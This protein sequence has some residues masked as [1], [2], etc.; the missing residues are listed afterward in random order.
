MSTETK[1]A[2]KQISPTDKKLLRKMFLRSLTIGAPLQYA[3][4]YGS[5]FEY[6]ILPF[7]DHYYEP[8]SEKKRQAIKRHMV[9]YNITQYVG[10]FCQGLVASMEKQAAEHDDYDVNS[11]NAVKASLMGPMSGIGDTLFWGIL[12]VIAAGVAMSF[13]MQGNFL[14]P[15][16]F[17][18]IYNIPAQWCRWEMTKLGFTVGSEY[19]T[20]M[21][22]SGLLNIFTKAAKTLG[23]IMLGGMTSS[24]VQFKSKLV[25]HVGG[26]QVI[27]VQNIL[28]SLL[29]GIVPLLLTLFCYWLIAKKHVNFTFV[30]LGLI[31][32]CILLS[33]CGI[34]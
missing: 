30:I 31:V 9:F 28:D 22:S 29:K 10:T 5:G 23:L 33:A 1:T 13:G 7:L 17:L 26:G 25:F 18:L 2:K 21:Y 20:D 24:L 14:A 6:S 27:N 32:L 16:I 15:F 11:I 19:I 12:R 34:A 8:N 3:N 4:E